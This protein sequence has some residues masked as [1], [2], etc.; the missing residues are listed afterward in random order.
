L[1]I[2]R[3][4]QPII[5]SVKTGALKVEALL[6]AANLLLRKKRAMIAHVRSSSKRLY[7]EVLTAQKDTHK[8]RRQAVR[9]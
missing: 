5:F 6:E 1:A 3:Q 4:L 8:F 9:D 7:H 2:H